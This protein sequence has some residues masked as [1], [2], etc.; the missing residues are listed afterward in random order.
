MSKAELQ[1]ERKAAHFSPCG[2][3]RYWLSRVWDESRPKVVF[4]GLNPST[5]G[6]EIQ[7]AGGSCKSARKVAAPSCEKPSSLASRRILLSRKAVFFNP[8]WVASASQR[9]THPGSREAV[10]RGCLCGALDFGLDMMIVLPGSCPHHRGMTW[11]SKSKKKGG[12]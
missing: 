1:P 12:P 10:S 8:A 4:I 5:A 11:W 7:E 2:A 3:Y 6:R 9:L